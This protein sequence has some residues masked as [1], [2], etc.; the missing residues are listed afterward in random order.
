MTVTIYY[1]GTYYVVVSDGSSEQ[2]LLDSRFPNV[3]EKGRGYQLRA[4]ADGLPGWPELRKGGG[5]RGQQQA[6][7]REAGGLTTTVRLSLLVCVVVFP[8]P[9]SV[10]IWQT[11]ASLKAQMDRSEAKLQEVKA[12]CGEEA[13]MAA[14]AQHTAMHN[15]TNV[16]PPH[17]LTMAGR[18]AGRS[19]CISQEWGLRRRSLGLSVCVLLPHAAA[20]GVAVLP[21]HR[22]RRQGPCWPLLLLLALQAAALLLPLAWPQRDPRPGLAQGPPLLQHGRQQQ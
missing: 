2:P 5:D 4:Y 17:S 10:S 8:P 21:V 13:M 9:P 3:S 14:K 22:G 15:L 7:E 1:R 12:S 19:A 16:R 11:Q 18:Q 20:G 6:R